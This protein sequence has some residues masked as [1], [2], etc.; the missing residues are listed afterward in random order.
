[1]AEENRIRAVVIDPYPVCCEGIASY[2]SRGGHVALGQGRDFE[3][4][5]RQLRSLHPNL[6]IL[7]PHL[8]PRQSL[9]LCREITRRWRGIKVIIIAEEAKNPPFLVDA[10]SAGAAACLHGELDA[11]EFL[12]VVE[13]VMAGRVLSSPEV[14]SQAFQP[15]ALTAREKEVLELLAEGKTDREVAAALGLALSTVRNHSQRILEKLGVHSRAEAV[16]R[17]RRR[18]WID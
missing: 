7:G 17:A 18:G 3:N 11:E 9:A 2:L 8:Q 4:G 6:A 5:L 16:G 14:L 12:S 1:M 13:A 15:I 10:A